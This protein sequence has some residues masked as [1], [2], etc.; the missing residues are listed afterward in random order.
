MKLTSTLTS[1]LLLEGGYSSNVEYYTGRYQPGIEK[2]RYSPAWYTRI[3]HE[4]L[5]GYGTVTP[6]RYWNGI[7]T[8]S[9][10]TD[11]RV[12]SG[13]ACAA[14]RVATQGAVSPASFAQVV[15][16]ECINSASPRQ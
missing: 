16:K 7:N 6:F 5:T 2:E 9:N 15:R 14:V 12:T 13:S 3:G 4:E 10:G 8:P 1:R 11:P